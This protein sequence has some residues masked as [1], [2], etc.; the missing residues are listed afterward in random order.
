MRANGAEVVTGGAAAVAGRAL[1]GV[2]FAQ[3]SLPAL[4]NGAVGVVTAT[5][6]RPIALMAFTIVD[7][8]IAAIDITDRPDRVPELALTL[9]GA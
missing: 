1:T 8:R 7:G 5:E 2:R 9:L 6:G 4:I 3:V